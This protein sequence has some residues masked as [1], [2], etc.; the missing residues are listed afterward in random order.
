MLDPD[1][2]EELAALTPY[3]KNPYPSRPCHWGG[4]VA[5]LVVNRAGELVDLMKIGGGSGRQ[6][7][8]SMDALEKL[9][10][11]AEERARSVLGK[12]EI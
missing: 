4:G 11:I 8:G 10:E 2:M 7:M 1:K 3:Y 9:G 12:L 5:T 6:K